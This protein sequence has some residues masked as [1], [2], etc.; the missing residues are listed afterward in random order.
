MPLEF[1]SKGGKQLYAVAIP[2]QSTHCGHCTLPVLHGQV[3]VTMDAPY[4]CLVHHHCLPYFVYNGRSRT[5]GGY[6]ALAQR[7]NIEL[8]EAV[9]AKFMSTRA[10]MKKVPEECRDAWRRMY[11]R[12]L[13]YRLNF[14]PKA[15]HDAEEA[16]Q[17]GGNASIR[18][19]ETRVEGEPVC[20]NETHRAP[21]SETKTIDY[22][23]DDEGAEDDGGAEADGGAGATPDA[24]SSS[25]AAND[26]SAESIEPSHA[27][28]P[29]DSDDRKDSKS[30]SAA[31][32]AP[33][34][35]AVESA[36]TE[37]TPAAE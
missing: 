3:F 19:N 12:A 29:N 32:E 24:G 2:C 10:F 30:E 5:V 13:T 28:P 16:T 9:V 35:E 26:G 1:K 33:S 27:E 37:S 22:Q 18:D 4:N 8:E 34:A 21:D 36:V 6:D 14:S 11:E 25:T 17:A 31:V 15:L 23:G 7:K 20:L